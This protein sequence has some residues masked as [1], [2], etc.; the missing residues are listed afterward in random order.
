MLK[1]DMH[2]EK[3]KKK[4]M[5]TV[6]GFSGVDSIS[7]DWKDKKLTVTGDIDPVN[8]VNRLRKFCHVEI[9]S[10]GDAK[11]PEKK[12]KEPEKQE[13]Q[14][15]DELARAYRSYYPHETMYYH[16]SS[17]EDDPIACVIS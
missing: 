1:L 11:E 8:M 6:S 15:V 3:T 17:I 12:K 14:N 10:V 5:K 7:M 2:D 9:V 4:A 16:V 13:D